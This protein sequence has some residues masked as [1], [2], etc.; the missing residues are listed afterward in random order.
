MPCLVSAAPLGSCRGEPRIW[1]LPRHLRDTYD[2]VGIGD[3]TSNLHCKIQHVPERRLASD[4][5][6]TVHAHLALIEKLAS[7]LPMIYTHCLLQ[8]TFAAFLRN[9]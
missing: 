3:R 9:W 4:F 2:R 6:E 5:R 1:P 7:R 8:A